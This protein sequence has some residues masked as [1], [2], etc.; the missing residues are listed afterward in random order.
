MPNCDTG[1]GNLGVAIVSNTANGDTQV[2]C[3]PC[4][5]AWAVAL[6]ELAGLVVTNPNDDQPDAE[7]GDQADTGLVVTSEFVALHQ[8]DQAAADIGWR[9]PEPS[10][11][12]AEGSSADQP[13]GGDGGNL[14]STPAGELPDKPP[15]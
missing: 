3:G 7:D 8:Q 6:C 4:L 13:A 9:E 10:D 1:D 12:P 14:V 2:M 5:T 11:S 15:F